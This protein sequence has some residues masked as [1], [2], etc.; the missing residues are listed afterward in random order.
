MTAVLPYLALDLIA[1]LALVLGVYFPRHRR[2]DLVVA[3][4]GVNLGVLAVSVALQSSAAAAG[5]GLG[6][7]GVLSIIRLRSDELAQSE[8]AYYFAALALGLISG[9]G[10]DLVIAAALMGLLVVALAIIGHPRVM[11][12]Y[13]RQ[14]IVLDRALTDP[15]ALRARLESHLGAS[16]LGVTVQRVDLVNDT[17]VVEV[18]Y[19]A[20]APTGNRVA[21]VTR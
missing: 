4:L 21:E 12:G 11:R 1:I 9:L 20:A 10:T 3:Y 8:V 15:V 17:T 2:R 19:R 6:L 7:F 13:A 18:R 14:V 16:V 5:L